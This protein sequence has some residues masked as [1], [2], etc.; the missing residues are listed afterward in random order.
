MG[1]PHRPED[2]LAEL[3]ARL[4]R[5]ERQGLRSRKRKV[6][7]VGCSRVERDGCSHAAQA[8]KQEWFERGNLSELRK[9]ILVYHPDSQVGI[10]WLLRVTLAAA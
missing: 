10:S 1:P 3:E 9:F 6:R 2:E 4:L 5:M 8:P 7:A